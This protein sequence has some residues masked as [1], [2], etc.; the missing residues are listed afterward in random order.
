MAIMRCSTCNVQLV[1]QEEFV[2]FQCPACSENEI[3]RCARCRKQSN[4]YK[5]K[6]GFEGP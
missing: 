6:C 4:A 3:I 1:G 5:C 2:R